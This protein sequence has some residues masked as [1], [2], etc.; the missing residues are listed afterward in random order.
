MAEARRKSDASVKTEAS[1]GRNILV[2]P[3]FW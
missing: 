2:N 1:L 3:G